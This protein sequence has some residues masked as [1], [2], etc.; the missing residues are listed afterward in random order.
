MTIPLAAQMSRKWANL[1]ALGRCGRP[2]SRITGSF[3]VI[4]AQ[5]SSV[6]SSDADDFMQGLNCSY[7]EVWND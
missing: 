3:A 7:T 6:T 2:R 4:K 5:L 1:V